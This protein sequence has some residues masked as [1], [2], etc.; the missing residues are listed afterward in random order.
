MVDIY[1][2]KE[3]AMSKKPAV[4][5]EKTATIWTDIKDLGVQYYAMKDKTISDVCEPMN[6]DADNLYV[7]LKG[8][9]A[10]VS[11]EEALTHLAVKSWSGKTIS[12]YAIEQRDQYGFIELNPEIN[13]PAKK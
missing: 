1:K 11:I 9:A 3:K 10:L 4:L 5:S 2:G 13:P 6:I 8:P 7:T 12:K